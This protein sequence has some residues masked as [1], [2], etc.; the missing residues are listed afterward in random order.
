M[1]PS[2]IMPNHTLQKAPQIPKK[3]I[4]Q[5][6]EIS[7][8]LRKPLTITRDITIIRIVRDL[9]DVKVIH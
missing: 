7:A 8:K 5:N 1:I 6:S 3:R 9:L 4:L 2:A